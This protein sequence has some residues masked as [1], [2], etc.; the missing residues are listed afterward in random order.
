MFFW[1]HYITSKRDWV[2]LEPHLFFLYSMQSTDLLKGGRKGGKRKINSN[3]PLIPLTHSTRQV[4]A[5]G[6][7][8]GGGSRERPRG[9]WRERNGQTLWNERWVQGKTGLERT[10]VP[11]LCCEIITSEST[12]WVSPPEWRKENIKLLSGMQFV[13]LLYIVFVQTEQEKY[14]GSCTCTCT[15]PEWLC[16]LPCSSYM[17]NRLYLCLFPCFCVHSSVYSFSPSFFSRAVFSWL[18][19]LPSPPLC[20]F[21]PLCVRSLS[22]IGCFIHFHIHNGWIEPHPLDPLSPSE[23]SSSITLSIFSFLYWIEVTSVSPRNQL[24]RRLPRQPTSASRAVLPAVR[25]SFH[26]LS[27]LYKALY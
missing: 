16:W 6:P 5:Q 15:T 22:H 27:L 24:Q 13:Y 4:T 12:T 1:F 21:V 20:S 10:P 17:Y 23:T 8:K 11:S 2:V 3:S 25:R 7:N 26:Q 19:L 14:E 18:V 9:G